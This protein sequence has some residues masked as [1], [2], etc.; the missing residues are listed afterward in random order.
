MRLGRDSCMKFLA[1]LG[2]IP[3]LACCEAMAAGDTVIH[4][5][6][7]STMDMVEPIVMLNLVS[8][9]EKT[10]V[11]K[12]DG[13]VGEIMN[14]GGTQSSVGGG[15]TPSRDEVQVRKLGRVAGGSG[16]RV[17]GANVLV[18]YF[19]FP[20]NT[21]TSTI[22]VSGSSCKYDVVETLKPGFSTYT[23]PR[24]DTGKIAYFK[25]VRIAATSCSIE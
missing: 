23:Y 1:F 7:D 10:V 12:A 9:F 25:N 17:K 20:Q 2:V 21:R 6:F 8:R 15:P 11:L 19:S 4:V 22:T 24:S 14:Y 3:A 18:K 5:T 16:W 13:T